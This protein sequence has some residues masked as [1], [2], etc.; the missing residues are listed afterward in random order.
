M[1]IIKKISNMFAPK[2]DAAISIAAR[3]AARGR[4]RDT[5]GPRGEIEGAGIQFSNNILPPSTLWDIYLRVSWVRACVNSI[6][7]T[8]TGRGWGVR[9][10]K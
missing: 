5:N 7:R 8:A 9:P 2:Q 4:N 1:N 6:T 10:K 3:D